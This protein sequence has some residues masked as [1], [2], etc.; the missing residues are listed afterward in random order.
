MLCL[1]GW[2]GYYKTEFRKGK[3]PPLCRPVSLK[4]NGAE[5]WFSDLSLSLCP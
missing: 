5:A 2:V 3:V 4:G 1:P